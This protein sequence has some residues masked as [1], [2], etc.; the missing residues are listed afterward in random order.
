MKN[1]KLVEIMRTLSKQEMKSFEKLIR[2]PYFN[3][4]R[5][6]T[7]LFSLLKRN[8][9]D[10]ESPE[11]TKENLQKALFP[12][13]NSGS[14]K[15]ANTIGE[16]TRLADKFLI[17]GYLNSNPVESELFLAAQYSERQTEK[18]FSRS[19][20][21]LGK[22]MDENP[23]DSISIFKFEEKYTQ[24]KRE[25]HVSM[26]EYD[27]ALK[28][29]REYIEYRTLAFF[30]FFFRTLHDQIRVKKSYKSALDNMLFDTVMENIDFEKIL[31][32]LKKKKYPMLWLIEM[33][34]N[35][36]MSVYNANNEKFF[37]RFRELFT[38]NIDKFSHREKY[39]IFC[40]FLSFC[41][42]RENMGDH[43][44]A[45]EEFKIYK[46]MM[47]R[48]IYCSS[49]K[50][51]MNLMLYRNVMF[52]ALS[53]KEH[54]WLAEFITEFSKKLKPEYRDAAR[55]FSTAH[56]D[57]ARG[58]FELAMENIG[59]INYDL[60]I[61]KLDVRN[62]LLKIFYELSLFDQAFS[63]VETYRWYLRDTEDMSD[64][65]KVQFKN[66]I[67][68]YPAL[69]RAKINN[70]HSSLNNLTYE[71]NKLKALH[72]RNWLLEKVE[73]IKK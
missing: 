48:N 14:K 54:A 38:E 46:E 4:E 36:Y 45:K 67:K 18:L 68:V 28:A 21:A 19:L 65:Y 31:S 12:G 27:D 51:Y 30:V 64:A 60:D 10:F 47:E 71:I 9:P 39:F 1:S 11:I 73:E 57:F 69:L 23:L 17:F 49:E 25:Y 40:D 22:R 66:F 26:N 70:D 72:A 7:G 50:D 63:L 55:F 33:Y 34:Y 59:M 29:H 44:F 62:L 15:L 3:I 13:E 24:L 35:C 2:S 58:N 42:L 43:S 52:L 20:K 16:L 37:Y 8:H 6:V 56:L 53:L 61:Y 41:I 5:D 32:K